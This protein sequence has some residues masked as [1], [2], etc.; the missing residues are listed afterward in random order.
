MNQERTFHLHAVI[1]LVAL[2]VVL[3]VWP[4]EPEASS[5][6]TPPDNNRSWPKDSAV[7]VFVDSRLPESRAVR[8]AVTSWFEQTSVSSS[9]ITYQFVT[10]DPGLLPNAIRIVNDPS[11]SPNNVAAAQQYYWPASPNMVVRGTIWFNPGFM[12]GPGICAYDPSAPGAGD[13][14]TKVTLHELG[15]LFGLEH[16]PAPENNACLQPAGSSVMNGFCG[17]NDSHGILPSEPTTCDGSAIA[18]TI[19]AAASNPGGSGGGSTGGGD[20]EG[21]VED[22]EDPWACPPCDWDDETATLYCWC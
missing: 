16:T 17:V 21:N 6:V 22:E 3:A 11:G 4:P 5:C 2:C 7:K 14:F 13:F 10:T 19:G 9:G 8:A 18:S 20:S 12:I 1:A 15:H